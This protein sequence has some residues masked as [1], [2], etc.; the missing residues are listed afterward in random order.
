MSDQTKIL[1]GPLQDEIKDL[2]REVLREELGNGT[3]KDDRLI[4]A[5]EAALLLG[6]KKPWLYANWDRLPFARKVGRSLKFSYLGV[7]KYIGKR[8]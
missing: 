5:T 7:Q 4:N 1:S 6:M 3:P 8:T 2:F